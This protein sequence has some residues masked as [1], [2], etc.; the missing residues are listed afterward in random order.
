MIS[1]REISEKRFERTGRGY[2]SEE[3][4][5]FLKEVAFSVAKIIK[6][7]DESEAKIHK[8]V[9]KVNQYREDEDAIKVAILGAQKQGKQIIYDAEVE[10]ERMLSEAKDKADNT[11]DKIKSDYANEEL[12]LE[13]LKMEVSSFKA[14]L[15]ELY[16][17]QLQL[18]LQIPDYN[19]EDEEETVAEDI[20]NEVELELREPYSEVTAE[21]VNIEPEQK[22]NDA[23]DI[24][25][26]M[27]SG[28]SNSSRFDGLKFG[29]NN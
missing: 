25:A 18:I 16:N 20:G 29:N 23:I 21:E 28:M 11:L 3:V 12:K 6:S 24:S 7:Y 10:A 13:N 4:D 27:F 1:P 5:S 8:L 2:K 26:E 19:V 22:L 9:E 14:Q 15:T 17:R